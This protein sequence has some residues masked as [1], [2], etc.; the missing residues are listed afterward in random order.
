M[1]GADE[2]SSNY[3]DSDNS[4]T[5]SSFEDEENQERLMKE[6]KED[7]QKKIDDK[8]R[9]E[10]FGTPPNGF[11]FSVLQDREENGLRLGLFL[12]PRV[13]RTGFGIGFQDIGWD[14][15]N[16]EVVP[17]PSRTI[18]F[19]FKRAINIPLPG[20]NYE[21]HSHV[22]RYALY[23]SSVGTGSGSRERGIVSPVFTIISPVNPKAPGTWVFPHYKDLV[24]SNNPAMLRIQQQAS[25]IK[26]Y[27]ELGVNVTK[28]NAAQVTSSFSAAAFTPSGDPA[29]ENKDIHCLS[30]GY[31][32]IDLD[33]SWPLSVK[34]VDKPVPTG[35]PSS[36][37]TT[38]APPS[39]S[40]GQAGVVGGAQSTEEPKDKAQNTRQATVKSI[41]LP[42]YQEFPLPKVGSQTEKHIAKG[43]F[44]ITLSGGSEWNKMGLPSSDPKIVPT[45]EVEV[46][47]PRAQTKR[48]NLSLPATILYPRQFQPSLLT[49]RRIL[50]R[51]LAKI[52]EPRNGL[53]SSPADSLTFK[54]DSK[55]Y[56][57][58]IFPSIAD[59][60]VVMNVFTRKW[61]ET[62]KQKMTKEEKKNFA[63][64]EKKFTDIATAIWPLTHLYTCGRPFVAPISPAIP[65]APP[66]TAYPMTE[67]TAN[68]LL[69]A[70]VD[71]SYISPADF[72]CGR[73]PP[74]TQLPSSQKKKAD[75]KDAQKPQAASGDPSETRALFTPFRTSELRLNFAEGFM[76][77]L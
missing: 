55:D 15:Y 57:F 44:K 52:D 76:P 18:K 38:S 59:S 22:L 28:K 10:K 61:T 27:V 53:L 45:L 34:D 32:L 46:R 75:S 35:A 68:D 8:A 43:L 4:G 58:K 74:N 49:Y 20:E 3:S 9:R 73:I 13:S 7:L 21:I 41:S 6:L 26:L 29:V 47:D 62:Y 37:A 60:P 1:S 77:D 42:I 25:T 70:L 72:L 2:D 48:R 66:Q 36:A 33:D 69:D 51:R 65:F 12:K 19:V 71:C 63:N 31:C 17:T 5:D 64:I 23:D 39:E 67:K 50:A 14:F 16:S 11:D 40:G 24:L 56:L 54:A 30:N